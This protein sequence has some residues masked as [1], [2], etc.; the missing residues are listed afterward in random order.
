MSRTN[1]TRHIKWNE[2]CKCKCRLGVSVCKNKQR[3][4][5]DNCRCGC[6]ELIGKGI[7][8]KGFIQSS[9]NC[10]CEC[11]KSCDVEEYLDYANCKCRKRL[12][13]NLV[14]ECS[15]NTDEKK[16]HSNEANDYEKI[17]SSYS[18]YIVLLVIFFILSITTS[19]V[20]IY[21]HWHLKKSNTGVTNIIPSTETEIY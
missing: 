4:K 15:K 8:D 5:N 2:T 9:N 18:V 7:Y 19:S 3:W 16:S 17:C 1:E 12:V 21:F 14:G 10:E 13:D 20:F 11:D 6:K